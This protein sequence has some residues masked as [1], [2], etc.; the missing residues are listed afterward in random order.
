MLKTIFSICLVLV[1]I[2]L[3][4][5]TL[6]IEKEAEYILNSVSSKDDYSDII[7]KL[8][9][10]GS[11]VVPILI[12]KLDEGVKTGKQWIICG[13]LTKLKDKRATPTL[14]KLLDST[15]EYG[16]KICFI[17]TLKELEDNRI[18]NYMIALVNSSK[19]T[20]WVRFAALSTLARIKDP[21]AN[22][23]MLDK[24]IKEVKGPGNS[25]DPL[26]FTKMNEVLFEIRDEESIRRLIKDLKTTMWGGNKLK[27]IKYLQEIGNKNASK[28]KDMIRVLF[29]VAEDEKEETYFRIKALISVFSFRG[30]FN[31]ERFKKIFNKLEKL[32]S[33]YPDFTEEIVK[34][35]KDISK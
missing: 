35:K 33:L 32:S 19:E 28:T 21:I 9:Q 7:D 15:N 10:L 29:Q 23:E 25:D 31:E 27:I 2:S 20:T 22:L 8:C 3:G 18:R 30:K 11:D 6:F 13:A 16:M 12:Q 34:I 1:N 26:Y 17:D 14:L 5:A 4:S 24:I